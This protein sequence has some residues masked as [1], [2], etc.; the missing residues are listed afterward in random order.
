VRS[1]AG[2]SAPSSP[3]FA[4]GSRA[5][6]RSGHITSHRARTENLSQQ[7]QSTT[8]VESVMNT[9]ENGTARRVGSGRRRRIT[10]MQPQIRG[11]M[12]RARTPVPTPD[13]ALCLPP[14]SDIIH[15]SIIVTTT[16][17]E[18]LTVR[19]LRVYAVR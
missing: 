18:N 1:M 15:L 5:T 17:L 4:A 14:L 11:R 2:R 9:W 16:T 10:T 12:C 6:A 19:A 7:Q 8:G 13:A 3:K